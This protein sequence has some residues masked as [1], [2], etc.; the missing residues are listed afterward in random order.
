MSRESLFVDPYG[1]NRAAVER[2]ARRVLELVLDDLARAAERPPLPEDTR[3]PDV[4]GIPDAPLEED[5]LLEQLRELLAGS[6][7]AASPGF[8]GHMDPMP[9][10][11]SFLGELASAAINNNML[12][13]EMSPLFSRLE[14]RVLRELATLLG[15]GAQAGGIMLSGGSLAN[16]QALAVARNQAFGT[17]ERGVAG[18]A[19]PPVL[20]ASEVA[21][22]SIQKAAMLLGLGTGAVI[23]IETNGNSQMRPD[24]LERAVD[25]AK[26]EGK[27]P[28][29][30]VATAGTTTTGNIDPLLEI[31]RIARRH[32]LW[33]HVD[34][35]YGGALIFSESQRWRLDGIELADSV[36]FNPQKWLYVAK[37]CAMVLFRDLE[38]AVHAFRIPAPY[39]AGPGDFVNLGEISV[40][41]TRHAEIL[42]LWLSLQHL[43]RQGY[44]RL[45]DRSYRLTS[46]FLER[47]RQRPFLELAS[48]PETNIVCFRGAP[49]GIPEDRQDAWNAELQQHLLRQARVFLSLPLYRGRRWLRAV[50]LN[51]YTDEAVIDRLFSHLDRFASERP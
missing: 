37:T 48:E 22:V 11:I 3:L 35:A 1:G 45:L 21:H 29:C 47:V 5:A 41:G 44:A 9:A 19:S 14:S 28:F 8:I 12:S 46:Y 27:A 31:G 49:G 42:K 38:Q 23:P 7:N 50:L 4:P 20:F 16:L 25:R 43:G 32:G 24:A 26:R 34:A 2:L 10:T 51:P 30:V 6:M 13:L 40:Q 15:L 17:L 33:F 18:L 39:M 36:V